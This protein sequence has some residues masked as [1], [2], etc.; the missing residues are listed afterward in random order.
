MNRSVPV[1]VLLSCISFFACKQKPPDPSPVV[2]VNLITVTSQKVLYYDKYP[3]TTVAL[4]SVDLRPQV[5]GYITGIYFIEGTHVHKGQKLY[6]IDRRL[7]QQ[8]YD[9]A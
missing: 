6:E 5:Q 4:S 8:A 3:A 7:Y 9:A 1:L 2:P